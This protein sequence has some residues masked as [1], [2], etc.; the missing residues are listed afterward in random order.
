MGKPVIL[1]FLTA[2]EKEVEHTFDKIGEKSKTTGSKMGTLGKIGGAALGGI[3]TLAA[4][5]GLMS[6][7]MADSYET[8]HARLVTALENTNTTWGKQ[9]G[10]ITAVEKTSEKLGFTYADTEEA[11]ATMTRGT[12]SSTK[13]IGLLGVAQDLARAKGM[14]L[15]DAG[16]LVTKASEGQIKPLKALGID[17]PVAAGGALKMKTASVALAKAQGALA[18]VIAKIHGHLLKGPAAYLALQAAQGK[19]AAAQGK[20]ND[21][22]SAGNNII[23]ALGQKLSGSAANAADTFSGKM[24]TLKTQAK[25]MGVKI[26]LW[27]IPILEKLMTGFMK[28][29]AWVQL[30]WPAFRAAIMPTLHDLS[31]ALAAIVDWVAINWPTISATFTQIFQ[32]C[33]DVVKTFVDIATT[34]WTNF[35]GFII[36]FTQRAFGPVKEIISGVMEQVRGIISLVLDIIHGKWGKIWGDLVGIVSGAWKQ[37]FGAFRLALDTIRL[38]L[39][40]VFSIITAPFKHA[41]DSVVSFFTGLP[42]R[43]TGTIKAIAGAAKNVGLSIVNGIISGV[44]GSASAVGDFAKSMVNGLITLVNTKII[45]PIDS[46]IH[47]GIKVGPV[48]FSGP[49][50]LIPDIPRLANGAIVSRATLAM[51]GEAGA[52][53]VLPLNRPQ[54]ARDLIA[55]SGVMGSR[56]SRGGGGAAQQITQHITALNVHEAMRVAAAEQAWAAK[57]SGR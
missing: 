51:I 49:S 41:F 37:I 5:V 26:G 4:G 32:A 28:L 23:A 8:S 46:L 12:G 34:L 22:Q 31:V 14:S 24:L 19:V 17:L 45:D 25:D 48:H 52:E 29:V 10:A 53:M 2:G 27:L 42:G 44:T 15:A 55:A 13:A 39:D 43:I 20:L 11:L 54:R 21:A 50:H 7:K 3:I 36:G 35:G 9:K 33:T 47:G 57:T 38:L 6:L 40:V 1:R 16:L 30:N 56:S 18:L